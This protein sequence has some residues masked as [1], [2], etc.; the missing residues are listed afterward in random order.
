MPGVVRCPQ[1]AT[2]QGKHES[3]DVRRLVQGNV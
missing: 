1:R 3:A 2:K